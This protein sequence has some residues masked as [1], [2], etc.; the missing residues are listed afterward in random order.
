MSNHGIRYLC[1]WSY[2]IALEHFT[3]LGVK[4]ILGNGIKGVSEGKLIL[5]DGS[6]IDIDLTIWTAGVKGCVISSQLR[7]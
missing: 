7:N 4:F 5:E 1:Y 3:S 6:E 2:P